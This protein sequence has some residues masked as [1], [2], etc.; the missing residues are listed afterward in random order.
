MHRRNHSAFNKL[1]RPEAHEQGPAAQDGFV[2]MAAMVDGNAA[3][4]PSK[5][6][7]Q[8]GQLEIAV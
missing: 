4:D 2:T 3:V 8:P 6:L 5:P 1:H 7:N